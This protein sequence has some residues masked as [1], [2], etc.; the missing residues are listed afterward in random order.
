MTTETICCTEAQATQPACE[1]D[2]IK[3]VLQKNI[4]THAID[5]K[6]N[7]VSCKTAETKSDLNS[8][9]DSTINKTAQSQLHK[10]NIAKATYLGICFMVTFT[11][12][13][14]CQN[15]VSSIYDKM[16]YDSLGN[17]ALFAIYF[18]FG[19]SNIFAPSIV[20]RVSYKLCLILGSLGFIP[21]MAIGVVISGCTDGNDV[22]PSSKD[23][24][25][26]DNFIYSSIIIT[27]LILG[28][29]AAIY[30][31]TAG[32]YMDQISKSLPEQRGTYFGIFWSLNA[33]SFIIGAILGTV[34]LS[35]TSYLVFFTVMLILGIVAS[36]LCLFIPNIS[37]PKEQS[38]SS[39][40]LRAD[41]QEYWALVKTKSLHPLLLYMGFNGVIIAFYSGFLYRLVE[42]SLGDGISSSE[43]TT[44]VSYIYICLGVS[45]M[46]SGYLTGKLSDKMNQYKLAYH[47]VTIIEVALLTGLLAY[48]AKSYMICFFCAFLFG[49]CDCCLQSLISIISSKDYSGKEQIFAVKYLVSSIFLVLTVA[50]N[51]LLKNQEVY[52]FIMII[53][54]FQIM[55]S[56]AVI[57]LNKPKS[58]D[59]QIKNAKECQI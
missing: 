46:I 34:L 14:T 56:Y 44:Y 36:F 9:Q 18:A 55:A 45:Q 37:K 2:S 51:I 10:K 21:F 42:R 39:F 6:Q 40:T 32:N 49:F 53:F 38:K 48:M 57:S 5:T 7:E 13:N 59:C 19:I 15:M 25:C 3:I 17:I 12:F 24:Q 30:Y 52:Y 43:I 23:T 50:I 11:A 16:G 26:Q 4:D 1:S 8:Q 28:T 54:I 41:L 20:R 58:D 35:K 29:T 33:S 47:S 27:S 22:A 31:T